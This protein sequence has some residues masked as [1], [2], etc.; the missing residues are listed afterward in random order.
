M[1]TIE[2]I[3][4]ENGMHFQAKGFKDASKNAKDFIKRLLKT[5]PK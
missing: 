2:A 4:N 5:D 1:D 3:G